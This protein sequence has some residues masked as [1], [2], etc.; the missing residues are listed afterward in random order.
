MIESIGNLATIKA[1]IHLCKFSHGY[2]ERVHTT[3]I[4]SSG[5]HTCPKLHINKDAKWPMSPLLMT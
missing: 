4:T 5:I 3:K 1:I 2:I